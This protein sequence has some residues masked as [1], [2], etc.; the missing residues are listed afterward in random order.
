MRFLVF[1]SENTLKLGI[2]TERGV[3]D[4]AAACEAAGSSAPSTPQAFYQ[5]GSAALEAYASLL[6]KATFDPLYHDESELTL[7][8]VVP[9]PGKILCVGL[10]YRKHA[11]ETGAKEPEYPI[12]FSKFNNAIAAPGEDVPITPHMSMVDYEAEQLVVMGKTAKHVSEADALNYVL[13]YACANDLSERNFQMRS[14]Q[15]LIGKSLDKFLPIGPYL[16]TADE[17]GDPQNMTV[18]GWLN[19]ELRQNSTT[20]DMIFSVAQCIAYASQFM[21]LQPGDI[22]STGTP[23]GVILGMAE[24]VWMQPGDEYTVEIGNLGRLTNRM[25]EG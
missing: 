1:Q 3:L 24:K 6:E 22:I 12:L 14:G 18:R 20:A 16:V 2:K 7:A 10:N 21:T 25:V 5:Q 13:G 11:A 9:N 15:W 23:E 17:A 8:P 19:G 4:V